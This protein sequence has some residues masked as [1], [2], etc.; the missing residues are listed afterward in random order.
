[1]HGRWRLS[2]LLSQDPAYVVVQWPHGGRCRE[3]PAGAPLI[4]AVAVV[5]STPARFRSSG[6]RCPMPL[7]PAREGTICVSIPVHAAR[8]VDGLP[9]WRLASLLCLLLWLVPAVTRA[10][11]IELQQAQR[12]TAEGSAT[13][14]LPDTLQAAPGAAQ[15]LRATYRMSFRLESPAH[16]IAICTPGLIANARIRVNGHVIE[17]RL[18]DPLA[19]LPRS[20]DRIRLIEVPEEFVHG[21]DNLLEI[22]A[23]GR[24]FI[25]IAPLSVGPL[26]TLGHRYEA[27][28]LGAVVG[29]ALVAVVVASL[30]LCLLLLWARRGDSL[31]GY[32]GL[33]ALGWAL[34]SAWSVLPVSPL[35]GP[36]LT[37]WWTSVY[38]FFVAM[39]VI[40][41]VRFAGWHW[42]RFDRVL[43]LLALMAP[44]LLYAA[45]AAGVLAEVQEAWLMGWIGVVAIGLT[46]VVRY[47]WTQRNANG[48]LLMATGAVSFT[49]A[50]RDWWVNHQGLDNNPVYLVPYAALLFMVLVAWML[51]D[52]FVGA[53]RELETVNRNLEQRVSAKSAELVGAL[54]QMRGA[55]EVA[56]SANRAK[57]TFLAAASHD[58]RQPVHALGLYMAALADEELNVGQHDL[59]RHMKSSLQSL[60]TMFNALL[61]V[62]RMDAG[63]VI[64]RQ[65]AFDLEPMLHRLAEEFAPLA[66]DKG[67]RLSVRVAPAPP[68]LHAWSDPML[69]ER[70]LRNLLGNAVKYTDAGG[71]LLSCRLR[72]GAAT[73]RWRVEVWD[74]GHGIAEADHERVFDEFFQIGNPER[75]RAGGLGLGLSIVRRMSELLRHR[76]ELRSVLGQGTRFVLDL[77]CTDDAPRRDAPEAGAESIAG[78]GVAVVEDDP[79]VRD[80]MRTLL[81]HWGCRVVAGAGVD[82]VLQCTGT[83]GAGPLHAIVADYRLRQ[84]RNGVD[85]IHELRA[86][87]GRALPALIVSGDSGPERLALM[88]ASGF[89]C[90]SKP[91]APARLHSWLAQAAGGTTMSDKPASARHAESVG[92]A[93]P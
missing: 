46:A 25:S 84:G 69:L 65:R 1:L 10:Q 56:E 81:E 63:A 82:E 92:E 16:R 45:A 77:P 15:P 5:R 14:R 67:L 21:G 70:I 26:A 49:F 90:L 34:H 11:A 40:F 91:V 31:Y 54:A 72:G 8:R 32:F 66:A 75:D 73:R 79:E 13:V 28:V 60:Q 68:Q 48:A 18:D 85:A 71:V 87:C 6:A 4:I 89:D 9:V 12:I 29:P 44:L 74:T 30:A 62:S 36:D 78:L 19:P 27:R 20:I 43:C 55:K 53:T 83:A 88:Q 76:L 80:S 59:V 50:L 61:D 7:G 23:A 39:L 38:S 64:P 58:L 51:I 17:D 3:V 37:V 42:P 57:S 41:C 24:R 86:A 35:T 47:A 2:I 52:R 93:S 33:G 22:E